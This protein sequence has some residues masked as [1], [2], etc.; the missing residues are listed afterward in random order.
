MKRLLLLTR[1]TLG[2]LI[3]RPEV[4]IVGALG[5]IFI[6]GVTLVLLDEE[7]AKQV[8]SGVRE[9]QG[10]EITKRTFIEG[11]L[12]YAEIFS[13]IITFLVGMNLIGRDIKSNAI[14]LYLVKPIKRDQ[15]FRQIFRSG[16]FND[17]YLLFIS[18]FHISGSFS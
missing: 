13:V 18:D 8:T 4:L 6:A 5:I 2:D 15:Y 10:I 1:I 14:G 11:A 17:V 12:V 16:H 9:S 3:R 7:L